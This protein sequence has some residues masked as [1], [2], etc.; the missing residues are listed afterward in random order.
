MVPCFLLIEDGVI[1]KQGV[2]SEDQIAEFKT[3]E[4]A[5]PAP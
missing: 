3:L 5:Q 4:S 2:L 1:V